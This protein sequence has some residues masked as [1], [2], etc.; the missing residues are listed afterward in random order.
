MEEECGETPFKKSPRNVEDPENH[1][2]NELLT[3]SLD[4]R[5]HGFTGPQCLHGL[6]IDLKALLAEFDNLL[7]QR[8]RNNHDSVFITDEDI[9]R[10]DPQV[11][12]ELQGDIDL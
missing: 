11:A 5:T 12:P 7:G 2:L 1:Y 6:L 10:V 8:R 3:Q 4:G 9:F